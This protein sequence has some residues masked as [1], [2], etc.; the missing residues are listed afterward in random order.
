M[1]SPLGPRLVP[2]GTYAMFCFVIM[3]KFG[4]KLVLLNL[5]LLSLEGTFSL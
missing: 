5:N 1:V 3:K 2:T 4:C